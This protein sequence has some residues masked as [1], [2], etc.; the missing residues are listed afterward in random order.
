VGNYGALFIRFYVDGNP[1]KAYAYFKDVSGR[2]VDTFT[3]FAQ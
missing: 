1:N 2:I 3:I